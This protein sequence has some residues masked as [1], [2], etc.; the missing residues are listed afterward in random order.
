MIFNKILKGTNLAFDISLEKTEYRKGEIVR[1]T[2][3]LKTK[4]SSKARQLM[5]FAEGKESTIITVSENMGANNSRDTTSKTYRELNIFFSKDL[6][7]LL[8]ESISSNILPDGTLEILPQ[9]KVIAFDFTLPADYNNLFSSYKGKHSSITYAVKATAD[10]AKKLDVNKEQQ[11]SLINSN[12]KIVSYSGSTTFD[13][14]IKSDTIN[15]NNIEKEENTLPS[16]IAEA[17]DGGEEE[18]DAGK[19]NY[20]A[21][22]ERI[23]GKNT[24]R[25]SP[26]DRSQYF[27]L[28]GTGMNYD[29]GT[30]FAK[31]REHFLKETSEAKINLTDHKDPNVPYSPGHPIKG[32]LI[33][34]HSQK[35]QQEGMREKVKAMKITLSG[36]EHAFAQGLQRVSTIE[37][38]EKNVKLDGNEDVG[39]IDNNNTIP[40]EFEIPQGVN[41]SYIG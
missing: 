24:N 2:L 12:N 30:I 31:G 23:F 13:A 5:L 7:H 21:R 9:N 25:D 28:S 41:Q 15:T 19:E 4:R 26:Q 38:Y 17:K 6:S 22:F 37:K 18:K 20:E 16:P 40:F 27:R 29:L 32:E 3:S 8:Q 35:E 34:L 36:I 14:D 33:L 39:K 1:G 11:F 10:I